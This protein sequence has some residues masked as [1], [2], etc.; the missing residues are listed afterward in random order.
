MSINEK[1]YYKSK[2]FVIHL[3]ESMFCLF[4]NSCLCVC[5]LTSYFCFFSLS[6]WSNFSDS[7][8][9]IQSNSSF[10]FSL[11]FGTQDTSKWEPSWLHTV[12]MTDQGCSQNCCPAEFSFDC[13]AKDLEWLDVWTE[14]LE[15][16]SLEFVLIE[17]INVEWLA[18][19]SQDLLLFLSLCLF[20]ATSLGISLRR[21]QSQKC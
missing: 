15:F 6:V 4:S 9:F 16:N 19:V 21:S 12:H 2:Y 1:E 3:I 14:W 11:K 13:K 5:F 10:A 20:L 8:V 7:R 17:M 18:S